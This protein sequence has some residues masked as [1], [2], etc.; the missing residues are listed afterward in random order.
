MKTTKYLAVIGAI[1]LGVVSLG[2]CRSFEDKIIRDGDFEYYYKGNGEYSIVGTTEQGLEKDTLI[3]PAYYKQGVVKYL[4]TS[5][6]WSLAA[7]CYAVTIEQA[8]KVYFAFL[9]DDLESFQGVE[10]HINPAET[11][12]HVCKNA[13]KYILERTKERNNMLIYVSASAFS[14]LYDEVTNSSLNYFKNVE[15]ENGFHFRYEIETNNGVYQANVTAANTSYYFNYADSPN[16]DLFFINDFERGG[17]IEPTPYEP[18]RKGYRFAGWYHEPE[19]VNAWD[20]ERDRLPVAEY[21]EAGNLKFI[22][23][24]L[25]AKWEK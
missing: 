14:T 23:T 7:R 6:Y 5:D 3:L 20:F 13:T 9:H 22:E 25:Y 19:C 24:K 15:L 12:V 4:R 1:V 16:E 18:Q 8:D 17:L 21:D 2:A 11:E 10:R